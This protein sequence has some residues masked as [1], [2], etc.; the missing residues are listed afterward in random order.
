MLSFLMR[1]LI[2]SNQSPILMTSFYLN[3]L[4]KTL[5]PD[6]VMLRVRASAYEFA[7]NT[8]Q[9]MQELLGNWRSTDEGTI[10][11]SR[12]RGRQKAQE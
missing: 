5:F 7:G 3:Y 10:I 12:E 11:L 9:S 8:V 4:L 2:L 6:T 1:T